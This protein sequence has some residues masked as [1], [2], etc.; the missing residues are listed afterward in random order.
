MQDHNPDNTIILF[1]PD[2]CVI[3]K[4][5][6]EPLTS[7]S[8][9]IQTLIN[10]SKKITDIDLQTYLEDKASRSENV[11][12]HRE[13]QR[14]AYNVLKRKVSKNTVEKGKKTRSSICHFN[15]KDNCPFCGNEAIQDKKK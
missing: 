10:Y 8:A 4:N 13:C 7:S 15:F 2:N 11:K 1:N 3:C 14:K 5:S 12:I 9:G 6:N